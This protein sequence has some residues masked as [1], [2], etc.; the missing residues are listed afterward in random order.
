MNHLNHPKTLK[1]IVSVAYVL[2]LSSIVCSLGNAIALFNPP[3]GLGWYEKIY[4]LGGWSQIK[5][6][7]LQQATDLIMLDSMEV[8]N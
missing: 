4:Q 7:R 8:T 3:L 1:W 5:T 6:V 2:L